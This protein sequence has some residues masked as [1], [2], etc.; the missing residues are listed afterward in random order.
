MRAG[1]SCAPRKAV[2]RLRGDG[3][4]VEGQPNAVSEPGRMP[5]GRRLDVKRGAAARYVDG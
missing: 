3:A 2:E 5:G 1:R 4:Y